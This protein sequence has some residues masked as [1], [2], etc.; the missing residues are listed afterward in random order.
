MD[1]SEPTVN[2]ARPQRAVGPGRDPTCPIYRGLRRSSPTVPYFAL[3]DRRSLDTSVLRIL[4]EAGTT[5]FPI[6]S[7]IHC[8]RATD[9]MPFLARGELDKRL[10]LMEHGARLEDE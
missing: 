1:L 9:P 5:F 6:H 4:S 7:K 8:V 3:Q 10:S 2:L